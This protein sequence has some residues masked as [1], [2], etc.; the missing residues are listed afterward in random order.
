M[1]SFL[2]AFGLLLSMP[3]AAQQHY[4][5]TQDTL[6]Y[7]ELS[8]ATIIAS[9]DFANDKLTTL[10]MTG[11]T[12]HFF[13]LDFTFGGLSTMAVQTYGD[14]RIDNDSSTVIID[15]VFGF[16]DSLDS[17]TSLSWKIDG[18]PGN[19]VLKTQWKN[20]GLANGQAGN[21]A[22]FQIWLYQKSGIIE[23]RYGPRSASNASGFTNATGPYAGVF[24]SN[25]LFTTLYEKCWLF[26]T[27]AN[28]QVDSAQNFSFKALLGVPDDGTV[29]RF[30]PKAYLDTLT[31]PT[32]VQEPLLREFGLYP[33]PGTG[34]VHLDVPSG[35]ILSV[36]VTDISGRQVLNP[37]CCPANHIDISSLAPG[38]YRVTVLTRDKA[39]ARLLC[40][41]EE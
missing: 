24:Y 29:Y 3:L 32:A 23:L 25:D 17:N 2:P 37:E 41:A 13:G 18:Q 4:V 35:N 6:S 15:G 40:R 9:P 38:F 27:P 11:K 28:I 36:M 10:P 22:N 12:Y 19:E 30:T 21:Y 8:G 16:L 26:G 31:P 5:F 14:M 7:S 33:N 20:V 34:I 39:Y 1:I